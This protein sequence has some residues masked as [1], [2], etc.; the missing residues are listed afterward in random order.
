MTEQQAK[1][2][3]LAFCRSNLGYSEGA[4]NYNKFAPMVAQAIGWNAQN[5]P[6]CANFTIAVFVQCF[7]L[8]KGCKML[9]GN[10][11]T[12]S[13][14][15]KSNS[16]LFKSAGRFYPSPEVGDVIFFYVGDDVNHQGI[17]ESISNGYV[18]TIEGNSSDMVK[19]NQYKC[20]H[21]SIAGYGRP[22]WDIVCDEQKTEDKTEEASEST[23][24]CVSQ[25]QT[26][27]MQMPMQ[28]PLLTCKLCNEV[29]YDTQALQTLLVLRG[30]DCT[31]NGKYDEDTEIAV[32]SA[33]EHYCIEADGECGRDTW[34]KLITN[35]R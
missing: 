29:R 17:V 4:N 21:C 35:G 24:F 8:E 18:N 19:R 3:A 22:R 15:C 7:G 34:T 14:L 10:I 13:A 28:I 25:F 31:V 20:G 11:G 9:C 27:T 12:V 26:F 16:D 33:Q 30:F 6:W 2:R 32:K 1:E 5:Q 23:G